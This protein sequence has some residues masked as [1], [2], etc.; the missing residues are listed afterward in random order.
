[1][2]SFI[3]PLEKWDKYF[4]SLSWNSSDTVLMLGESS[5]TARDLIRDVL[6]DLGR[7]TFDGPTRSQ[8]FKGSVTEVPASWTWCGFT[9]CSFET[10]EL[11][12]ADVTVFALEFFRIKGILNSD[13]S[14]SFRS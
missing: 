1:M 10:K 7:R 6:T 14:N 12:T 2:S 5:Y 8:I 13:A 11:L 3:R 4:A 9:N